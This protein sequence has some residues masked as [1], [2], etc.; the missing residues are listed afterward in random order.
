MIY[1]DFMEIHS[2][3]YWFNGIYSDSMGYEWDIPSGENPPFLLGKLTISMA[4]F[5]S[6]LLNYQ[7]GTGDEWLR[8]VM[9][10]NGD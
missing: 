10:M 8:I 6:K 4:M 2:D 3:L 7:R 5:N 9:A 1:I